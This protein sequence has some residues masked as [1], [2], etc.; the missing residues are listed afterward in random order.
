VCVCVCMCLIMC[1]LK[2]PKKE[3]DQ[4]QVEL[5]RHRKKWIC[6]LRSLWK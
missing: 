4:P 2:T 1:D 6:K 5:L 3:A